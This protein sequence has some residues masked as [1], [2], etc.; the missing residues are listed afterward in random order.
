MPTLPLSCK[1][2]WG[3]VPP[4]VAPLPRK[5]AS[6]VTGLV[7]PCMLRLPSILSLPPSAGVTLVLLK[8]MVGKL[9]AEKKFGLLRSVSRRS[10]LVLML[11]VLISTSTDEAAGFFSSSRTL[12]S[13]FSP[14]LLPPTY[15]A[16][17]CCAPRWWSGWRWV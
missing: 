17:R 1:V 2:M 12:P 16:K 13:T 8:V 3:V 10:L 4:S 9:S 15:R 11:A 7:M 14:V 5:L 6:S